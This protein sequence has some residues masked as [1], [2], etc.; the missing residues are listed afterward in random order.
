VFWGLCF[1]LV[2]A[3]ERFIAASALNTIQMYMQQ[4]TQF[5]SSDPK[6]NMG[7]KKNPSGR[8]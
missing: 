1:L 5:A 2:Y 7:K 3:K 8:A 4:P 6:Q